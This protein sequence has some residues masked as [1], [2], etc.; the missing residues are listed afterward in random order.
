MDAY[1]YMTNPSLTGW[2]LQR[3]VNES[4]PFKRRHR[5]RDV[6]SK[7]QPIGDIAR[8]MGQ[9]A[10]Q[11][12]YTG[13]SLQEAVLRICGYDTPEKVARLEGKEA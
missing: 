13:E 5:Q 10:D 9:T 7:G 11:S 2:K 8:T 12:K 1:D 4:P 3:L 6:D